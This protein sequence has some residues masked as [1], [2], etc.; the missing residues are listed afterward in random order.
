MKRP[1]LPLLFAVGICTVA[2]PASGQEFRVFTNQ[3][4]ATIKA[5]LSSVDGDKV[6]IIREDGAPFTLSL[7]QLSAA[8]Q[9]YVK[10]QAAA[11]KAGS[12]PGANDTITPAELNEAAGVE[13][14]TEL[15][16]WERPAEEV[17]KALKLNR[18]SQ[19]KL[20][21]SYRA[22]PGADRRLFNAR[23]YSIALYA[24]DGKPTSLSVVYANKGDSFGA[25]GSGEQ[26]FDKDAPPKEAA[27]ILREAMAK[28]MAALTAAFQQK[29]GE[30]QRQ[31]FGEGEGRR[32]VCRWDWRGHALLL[33]ETDGEYV[34]LQIET[35]TFADSGGRIKRTP[36][37]QVRARALANV[38]KRD[39]GDVVIDDIPMVDQGPKGY[40]AP[41]TAERAMRYLDVPAD[42]YVLAMAGG[43][44][45]GGG[46]SV[47][48]LLEGV[49]RDLRRKGRNFDSWKGELKWRDIMKSID[50]GVPILWSMHSTKEFNERANN[51]TKTRKSVTD[52][53]E[54]SKKLASQAK[55][56][57]LESSEDAAHVVL[58]IG[59]NKET[60]EIA[61]SDSWGENYKERWIALADAE[62][63]SSRH[64]WAVGF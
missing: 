56:A 26:H 17:A 59:Y 19:T 62:K 27:R 61:F 45:Y 2:F 7:S 23:P 48:A 33:S 16:F 4:G 35:I 37:A 41:A 49:E 28:D 15:S 55:Q 52:W 38:Q 30:P 53:R 25:K 18:E 1:F 47:Q 20:Q 43:S 8:D 40:C 39:N 13:L 36:E 10:S 58:I 31:R 57:P 21:S 34:G 11:L 63:I 32:S 3:K 24:A 6:S 42:M 44:G 5:K 54:W 29:L 9:A 64:F 22:Y 14:F 51:Q 46:T 12:K 50:R 60:G